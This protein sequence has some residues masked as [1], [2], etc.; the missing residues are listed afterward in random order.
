MST[1]GTLWYPQTHLPTAY[2][3]RLVVASGGGRRLLDPPAGL[4]Y[5]NVGHGRA[6]IAEAAVAQIRTLETSGGSDSIDTACKLA[7][8]YWQA[9][10]KPA[11]KVILSHDGAYH[12]L[13]CYGTSIAGLDV[14]RD[15][16]GTDSLVL[17]TARVPRADLAATAAV[18]NRI[19]AAT[20]AAIVVEPVIGTG[21]VSPPPESDLAGLRELAPCNDILF[22]VDE[23]IAGFGRTRRV[24]RL[25]ALRHR[26]RPDHPGHG[27]PGRPRRRNSAPCMSARRSSSPPRRS[28][29]PPGC[30]PSSFA[31][32][33]KG[34]A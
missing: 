8:Q 6:R 16:Y 13:P 11:K 21:G 23:V 29:S 30:S 25:A 10:G 27:E 9:V 7:R 4:W 5:A 12:G 2:H 26:T 19:G 15:G 31:A 20:I 14:N 22:V 33:T 18:I 32:A 1:R 34:T 28:S 24:V 3:Q 17:E